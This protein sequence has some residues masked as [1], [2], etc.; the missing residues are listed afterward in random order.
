VD[1]YLDGRD[2]ASAVALRVEIGAYLR[3]HAAPGSDVDMSEVAVSELLANL[4]RHAPGPAWVSLT[5]TGERPVLEVRDLGPGFD[6]DVADVPSVDQTGGRGLFIASSF[7]HDLRA[8]ARS[9][10]GMVVRAELDVQRD[11]SPSYDPEPSPGHALPDLGEALPT[12]GFGRE[13]FLRALVVQLAQAIERTGGPALAEEAVAQVGIDVGSQM[14]AEYRQAADVVGR[15]APEQLTE[16]YL[17]LKHAIDG[18]FHVIEVTDDRIVL[19]ASR[20]PFG[21]VVQDDVGRVRRHR[22][23]QPRRGDGR[24]RGAHRGGRSGVSHRR[25][26]GNGSGC[27]GGGAPLR[28][29]PAGGRRR[30]LLTPGTADLSR[31]RKP[32]HRPPGRR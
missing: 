3:R 4:P 10:G 19:G 17:R 25:A 23:Q 27:T 8:A 2:A 32:A 7:T 24:A 12:G 28:G 29:A 5:W 9:S 26:P 1:W 15:L 11:P 20:C 18:R 14:E 22:R 30:R 16:C 6:L 31:P 13:S 21:D